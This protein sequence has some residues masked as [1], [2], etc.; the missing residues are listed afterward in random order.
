MKTVAGGGLRVHVKLVDVRDAADVPATASFSAEVRVCW[1]SDGCAG[2][3]CTSVPFPLPTVG[4][5]CTSGRCTGSVDMSTGPCMHAL[6]GLLIRDDTNAAF[7]EPGLNPVSGTPLAQRESGTGVLGR[8]AAVAG[9]LL[10]GAPAYAT[11]DVAFK[12]QRLQLALV[13]SHAACVAPNTAHDP[14]TVVP[15]C[16]P[17]AAPSSYAFGPAG[18]GRAQLKRVKGP[19]LQLQVK[20]TDVRDGQDQRADG[21]T[22]T[23]RLRLRVTNHGCGGTACTAEDADVTAAI[24]CTAGTCAAKASIGPSVLGLGV[25]PCSIALRRLEIL[26]DESAAFAEAGLKLS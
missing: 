22:F 2:Q 24:T 15:A 5:A 19:D 4:V 13:R 18:K 26:D 21:V 20:L 14:P 8:L 6:D 3:A 12:A 7:A 17:A 16:A 1:T 23:A 9:R 25:G 11:H 10:G